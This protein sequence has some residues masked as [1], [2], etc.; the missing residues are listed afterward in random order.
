MVITEITYSD[1]SKEVCGPQAKQPPERVHRYTLEFKLSAVRLSS[2]SGVQVQQVAEALDI[3]P[4]MLSRWRKEV[5]QDVAM[6]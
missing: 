6:S 2:M 3:H 5:H 4:F 1:S